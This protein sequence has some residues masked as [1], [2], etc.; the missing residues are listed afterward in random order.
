MHT[1]P[2]THWAYFEDQ[3]AAQRCA[4]ELTARDFLCGIDP[5]ESTDPADLVEGIAAGRII[6][7]ANILADLV[8]ETVANLGPPGRWLVRA[9]R[10][11]AVDD[12]IQRHE[13]VEATVER[14]GGF[15]DGGETSLLDPRTGD[16]I[17]QEDA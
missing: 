17:Q 14:H 2:Y 16:P 10:E 9:A 13:L 6:G 15:Y 4:D 7:P 11:V 8:R 12:L 3:A 5:V 1:I